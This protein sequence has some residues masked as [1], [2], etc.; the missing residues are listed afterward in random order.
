MA[1]Y[2]IVAEKREDFGKGFARRAR[3]AGKVPAVLYDKHEDTKHILLPGHELFLIVK[4]SANALVEV[5][6]EGEK[7]LALVKDV[8]R[9]PVRR[10]ILHVDFLGVSRDEKVN[11]SV[12][13]E[14]ADEPQ[15]GLVAVQDTHELA[16]IAPAVEI[17]ELIKVFVADLEADTVVRAADLTLPQ[18]VELD[19]DPELEILTVRV[20]EAQDL[21]EEETAAEDEAATEAAAE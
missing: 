11:V 20:P 21:P 13:L 1:N 14:I 5:E 17:P 6:F 8:Q 15:P 7:H 4:D 18:D 16:I 9:H 2:K 10:D 19:V 3:A 12:A